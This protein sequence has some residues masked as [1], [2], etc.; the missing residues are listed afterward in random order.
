M[1]MIASAL[2]TILVLS[3]TAPPSA[4]KGGRRDSDAASSS[5]REAVHRMYGNAAVEAKIDSRSE[6]APIAVHHRRIAGEL[7]HNAERPGFLPLPAS[8]LQR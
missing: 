5:A 6:M 7:A 1:R 3:L 8:S 2:A 4:D